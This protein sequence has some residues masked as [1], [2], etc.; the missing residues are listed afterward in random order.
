MINMSVYKERMNELSLGQDFK[1]SLL[2]K[3]REKAADNAI[4]ENNSTSSYENEER[5]SKNR[6]RRRR[7]IIKTSLSV[8]C[9]AALCMIAIPVAI[10]LFPAALPNLNDIGDLSGGNAAPGD[11]GGDA[12]QQAANFSMGERATDRYGNFI[13]FTGVD[14]SDSITFD[15][16]T[17]VPSDGNVFILLYVELDLTHER[18]WNGYIEFTSDN[19]S[20]DYTICYGE[21]EYYSGNL[22]FRQ[23]IF[24]EHFP[25][26]EGR[27]FGGGV[28]V[29][30]T[31][32]RFVDYIAEARQPLEHRQSNEIF[33]ECQDFGVEGA[34]QASILTTFDISLDDLI[35]EEQ[36]NSDN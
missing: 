9:A 33:F 8:A 14:Y 28:L 21:N 30:E 24:D 19:I 15:G 2:D 26:P 6:L 3:I 35:E 36:K 25:K 18:D 31:D 16:Q 32:D 4:V 27:P 17:Y 13:E 7:R 11:E 1:N 34:V 20:A 5:E 12:P 23:D 10:A 29:S 22:T